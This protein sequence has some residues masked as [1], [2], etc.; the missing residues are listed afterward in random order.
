MAVFVL[1]TTTTRARSA[2][3]DFCC[4]WSPLLHDLTFSQNQQIE[5]FYQNGYALKAAEEEN[6]TPAL[7]RV[8][9]SSEV[10]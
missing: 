7:K 10:D 3:G 8:F 6:S 9:Q 5:I 4:P 1:F 2:S